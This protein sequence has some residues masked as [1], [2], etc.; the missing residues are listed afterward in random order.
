MT[1]KHAVTVFANSTQPKDWGRAVADAMAELAKP[2]EEGQPP[3]QERLFRQDLHLSIRPRDGG[4]DITVSWDPG[5]EDGLP[6]G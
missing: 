1:E 4:V 5:P 6:P 3:N 2:F